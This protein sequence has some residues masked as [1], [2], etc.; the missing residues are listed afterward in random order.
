MIKLSDVSAAPGERDGSKARLILSVEVLVDV[1]GVKGG[2]EG[3]ECGAETEA[4]FGIGHQWVKVSHVGLI[5]GQGQ[6]SEDKL[7]PAGNLGGN[8]T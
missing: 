1:E 7:T 5:K 4:L 2:V 3:A 6:L 8:D